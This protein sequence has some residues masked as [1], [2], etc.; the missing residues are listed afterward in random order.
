MVVSADER[1]EPRAVLIGA[2]VDPKATFAIRDSAE[3]A[4]PN[5]VTHKLDLGG[6]DPAADVGMTMI[7]IQEQLRKLVDD[8]LLKAEGEWY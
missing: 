2:D 5:V 1:V 6:E 7:R 8:G 3:R 4:L